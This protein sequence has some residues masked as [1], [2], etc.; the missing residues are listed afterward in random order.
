MILLFICFVGKENGI[1]K[2]DR[3]ADTAYGNEV[4]I[5]TRARIWKDVFSKALKGAMS[6]YIKMVRLQP[7]IE[8]ISC[9]YP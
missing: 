8:I 9:C 7:D 6:E 3:V 2:R 5:I 1:F 4:I